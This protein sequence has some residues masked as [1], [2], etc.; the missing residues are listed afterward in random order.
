MTGQKA[1]GVC[2]DDG[3]NP[4]F[5]SNYYYR[6]PEWGDW[7]NP[8]KKANDK[9][10]ATDMITGYPMKKEALDEWRCTT[11]KTAN[12]LVYEEAHNWEVLDCSNEGLRKSLQKSAAYINGKWPT[13]YPFKTTD[14]NA[15]DTVPTMKTLHFT[16]VFQCF[17]F[18]QVFNQINA[19]KLEEGELNVFGGIFK[20]WMFLVIVLLTVV[21]QCVMVELGGKAVKTFPLDMNANLICL[22]IGFGE[23][24]WGLL[25][26]FIPLSIVPK[27]KMND[28]PEEEEE[29]G[30]QSKALASASTIART[31]SQIFRGK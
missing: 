3:Y 6:S 15:L 31:R 25:L 4:Y 22:A 23:M 24:P 10:S 11:F 9:V 21:V 5:T 29:T 27:L 13:T 28:T 8:T 14:G 19:R 16:F 1:K 30:T 12:P 18:M 7:P 17:V 2:N 20:N 26:K